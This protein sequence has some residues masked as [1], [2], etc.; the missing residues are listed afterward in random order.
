MIYNEESTSLH[1]DNPLVLSLS[2]QKYKSVNVNCP[3]CQLTS[4]TS[5]PSLLGEFME[6]QVH[7]FYKDWLQLAQKYMQFSGHLQM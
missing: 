4:H 3:F 2:Q 1:K 6:F 7:R 5:E